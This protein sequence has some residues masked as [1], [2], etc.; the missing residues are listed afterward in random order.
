MFHRFM[1][2]ALACVIAGFASA[3]AAQQQ[4]TVEGAQRFLALLA[5]DGHLYVRAID[6]PEGDMAVQGT[7]KTAYRWLKNGALAAD[8][9]YADA[10]ESISASLKPIE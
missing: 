3:A 9:P 2:L 6:R 4:Q 1:P 7:R 5:K 10:S 8:G